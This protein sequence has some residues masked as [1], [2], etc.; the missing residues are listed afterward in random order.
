[1]GNLKVISIC[2]IINSKRQQNVAFGNVFLIVTMTDA[3]ES[4]LG[5]PEPR[6]MGLGGGQGVRR[7]RVSRRFRALTEKRT[8]LLFSAHLGENTGT[9]TDGEKKERKKPRER[10]DEA[11]EEAATDAFYRV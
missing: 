9:S 3:S 6:A 11:T 1:M 8:G 10:E 7:L 4:G 2:D 5:S